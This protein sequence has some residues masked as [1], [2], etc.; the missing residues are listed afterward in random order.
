MSNIVTNTISLAPLERRLDRVASATDRIERELSRTNSNLADV[1]SELS[2]LS[3]ELNGL[4][5]SFERFMDDS[6]RA[7]TLQK[8]ATELIR[9]RQEL[10]QNF[11][12]Y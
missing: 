8:A 2:E 10:E 1:S 7:A 5:A 11:G 3:R 12:S 9:V 6:R 4:K